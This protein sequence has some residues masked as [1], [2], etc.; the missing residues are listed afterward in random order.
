M[1]L[2]VLNVLGVFFGFERS[3]ERL[4]AQ[5]ATRLAAA[6]LASRNGQ[7]IV[8]FC[9]CWVPTLERA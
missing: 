8:S 7:L 1:R 2:D 9:C 6:P 4:P 3:A 5:T